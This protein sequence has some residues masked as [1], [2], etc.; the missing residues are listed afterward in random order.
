[1]AFLSVIFAMDAPPD[2]MMFPI[3]VV[4]QFAGGEV[5]PV[6]DPECRH[7]LQC[8]LECHDPKGWGVFVR[9][10]KAM[11]VPKP[12]KYV[13]TLHSLSMCDI[14]LARGSVTP[15]GVQTWKNHYTFG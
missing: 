5:E 11:L 8:G 1:M 9:K 10:L 2:A 3:G 7:E 13:L 12:K 15:T 14:E 6:L 4:M